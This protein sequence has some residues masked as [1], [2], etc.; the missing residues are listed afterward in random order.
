MVGIEL[1]DDLS[2]FILARIALDPDDP[3]AAVSG[4]GAFLG[5]GSGFLGDIDDPGFGDG[6]L[7]FNLAFFTLGQPIEDAVFEGFL[8]FWN[9]ELFPAFFATG[10]SPLVF[11]GE[12]VFCTAIRTETF[13]EVS[14]DSPRSFVRYYV[15]TLSLKAC[16]ASR[17]PFALP[18]STAEV[19]LRMNE[20]ES[21]YTAVEVY[22]CRDSQPSAPFT[23]G[24]TGLIRMQ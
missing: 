16:K 4:A 8:I 19:R 2:G 14:H 15:H 23:H 7:V 5:G 11:N 24:N 18:D 20:Y 10:M 1:F 6:F 9:F 12:A 3:A 22:I 13:D 17:D 21:D